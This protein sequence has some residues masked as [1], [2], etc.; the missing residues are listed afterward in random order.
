MP[1]TAAGGSVPEA[2]HSMSPHLCLP[3]HCL[4]SHGAGG[5]PGSRAGP[6]DRGFGKGHPGNRAW[7][8]G[9]QGRALSQRAR[10][11]G[12]R[13]GSAAPAIS[14]AARATGMGSSVACCQVPS[15]V[16]PD[17]PAH[18][19]QYH[20]LSRAGCVRA[21]Q[22]LPNPLTPFP[23]PTPSPAFSCHSSK[24]PKRILKL[25]S[26]R[27]HNTFSA[28]EAFKVFT[29]ATSHSSN[30]KNSTKDKAGQGEAEP[31]GPYPRA[32]PLAC[33]PLQWLR[34]AKAKPLQ[35]AAANWKMPCP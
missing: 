32:L 21:Q 14:H 13:P 17:L 30:L 15:N 20:Q 5:R 27:D 12:T 4:C 33:L 22:A 7:R 8:R 28:L 10:S 29:P 35:R 25:T 2:L 24:I 34:R 1:A 16:P 31:P 19:S 9:A 26:L 18:C 6:W 11:E 3:W 23:H